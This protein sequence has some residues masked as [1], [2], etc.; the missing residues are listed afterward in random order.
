MA[1]AKEI[2]AARMAAAA[3]GKMHENPKLELHAGVAVAP[4]Q[5]CAPADALTESLKAAQEEVRRAQ[6]SKRHICRTA[7]R[8]QPG[9]VCA[10]THDGVKESPC[11]ELS[12]DLNMCP[13]L[14]MVHIH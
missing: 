14:W 13:V 4:A 12:S 11:Y 2:M 10:A 3:G 7:F 8:G 1:E 9:T 6:M 5:S